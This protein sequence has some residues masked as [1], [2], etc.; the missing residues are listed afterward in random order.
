MFDADLLFLAFMKASVAYIAWMKS[1][2]KINYEIYILFHR[3]IIACASLLNTS[4]I[5][6]EYIELY[7]NK[8]RGQQR[9]GK[10]CHSGNHIRS[11]SGQ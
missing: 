4:L 8:D 10:Q 5:S 9:Q 7:I 6:L 3:F 11:P 1:Y 2:L